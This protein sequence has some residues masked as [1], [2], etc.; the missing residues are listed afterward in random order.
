M[1]AIILSILAAAF[2]SFT[3]CKTTK[4]FQQTTND[5]T[6]VSKASYDSLAIA[7][8]RSDSIGKALEL[9][10]SEVGIVF[11]TE[12]PP[13]D[14]S[15]KAIDTRPTTRF[16][17]NPDGS[18][19]LETNQPLKFIGAQ[20]LRLQERFDSLAKEHV[21]LKKIHQEFIDSSHKK[22]ETNEKIVSRETSSRDLWLLL[23]SLLVVLLIILIIKK[24][25][26]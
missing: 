11:D 1:K 3:G 20:F 2:L 22:V 4:S 21:Q 16:I 15:I 12:C 23:A 8:H 25:K 24:N 18:T 6:V 26:S 5:S 13:P 19:S 10:M 14:T 7:K 17:T 9:Q